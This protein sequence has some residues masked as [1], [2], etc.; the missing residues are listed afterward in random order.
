MSSLS[1][2]GEQSSGIE[3]T[4]L[5]SY[6]KKALAGFFV[7]SKLPNQQKSIMLIVNMI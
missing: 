4:H 5:L 6:I 2:S 3:F 7:V 1:H